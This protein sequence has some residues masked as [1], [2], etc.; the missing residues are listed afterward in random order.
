MSQAT[1]DS[2][3]RP[4]R[5]IRQNPPYSWRAVELGDQTLIVRDKPEDTAECFVVT[6]I[7]RNVRSFAGADAVLFEGFVVKSI[8][9]ETM[10]SVTLQHDYAGRM[11]R[12]DVE[13][14]LDE[15]AVRLKR[16]PAADLQQQIVSETT[17]K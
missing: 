4:C 16:L 2:N 1:K 10:K 13:E 12:L 3:D 15:P 14:W 5:H 7:T 8:Y 11:R 17:K 9:D 6:T